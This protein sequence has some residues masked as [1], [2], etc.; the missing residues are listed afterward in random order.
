[1]VFFHPGG[2][3]GFS[4]QS[5]YFGPQYLLD[6]DVVLVTVN[7]RLGSLGFLS[8]GDDV[9][10]GNNGMKDQVIALRFIKENIVAYGGDPNNVVIMGYSAGSTSVALHMI[11]P[12][13]KGLFHKAI[14]MSASPTSVYKYPTDQK[15]IAIKQAKLLK[16]PSGSSIEIVECLRKLPAQDIASGFWS[17]Q[18]VGIDPILIW[19]P[20]IENG[21]STK[22]ESF[23]VSDPTV[24]FKNGNYQK[25]PFMTGVT[26]LEFIELAYCKFF[27][28]TLTP[29]PCIVAYDNFPLLNTNSK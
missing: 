26:A 24:E 3:Y 27:I 11:S 23:L 9:L 29:L 7:Y 22:G 17:F 28:P 18:E 5:V 20:V 13:S 1:M 16:C 21:N 25:V 14:A 8:F 12:M 10:P 19:S 15:E 2:F 6:H 4:G